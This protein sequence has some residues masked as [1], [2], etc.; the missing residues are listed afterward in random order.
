MPREMADQIG[1]RCFTF[2]FD[3]DDGFPRSQKPL[4]RDG[5]ECRRIKR[6]DTVLGRAARQGFNP[7]GHIRFFEIGV[8]PFMHPEFRAGYGRCGSGAEGRDKRE[9]RIGYLRCGV[10]RVCPAADRVA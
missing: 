1:A 8:G 7:A 9:K 2:D 6:G 3:G 5:V 4:L 10:T